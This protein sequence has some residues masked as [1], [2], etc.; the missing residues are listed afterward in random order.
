[1][2]FG[3]VKDVFLIFS[4]FVPIPSALSQESIRNQFPIPQP[5]QI[6]VSEIMADPAPA[7]QLP[8]EYVELF[9]RS[10]DSVNIFNWT[11]SAGAH[12]IR[13][14]EAVL[15]PGEYAVICDNQAYSRMASFSDRLI[16]VEMPHIT[17]TG[18]VITLRS[19]SGM[20]IHSVDFSDDWYQDADKD[21]GGWALEI[22]DPGNP[23]G[24]RSNW[25]AS[26]DIR[27][28]TPGTQ[29][30]VFASNPDLTAPLLLR[31]TMP[32]DTTVE[33]HFNESLNP[34]TAVSCSL[35]SVN[36][37]VYHPESVYPVEPG[38]SEILLKYH[39][40]FR[41]EITYRISIL[42]GLQDCAGN[43][44]GE[45]ISA[46]F[47]FAAAAESFDLVIN[48]ILFESG[49]SGE[50][51]EIYN[52]S[53]KVIDLSSLAFSLASSSTSIITRTTNFNNEQYLLFPG[54][55][56]VL[57]RNAEELIRNYKNIVP[58]TLLEIRSL[59]SLPDNEGLL[60]LADTA[61]NTIDECYYNR[62]RHQE[63]LSSTEGI[64]LERIN[65]DEASDDPENWHSASSA[66]EFGTPGLPNS[67][68]AA[69]D[70]GRYVS[71]APELLSPDGDGI[72][73]EVVIQL[74]L[75]EPGW[76]GTI[77]IY[78]LTGVRIRTL[79]SNSLVGTDEY[80][81][82]DGK[83][84]EGTTAGAGLYVVFGELFSSG[85]QTKK[86]KKVV[87]IVYK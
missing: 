3:N 85:G 7:I 53:E 52:R 29:N 35:Y 58:Q 64:S 25:R 19:P 83:D 70:N 41:P 59:F 17:N 9:N 55:Y 87:P 12:T 1:M 57:T 26:V 76:F 10:G 22:I 39:S 13:I 81:A 71:L 68:L 77:G 37:G 18:Q 8:D 20:V 51:V 79:I 80:I 5:Y 48:E 36:N 40:G 16:A 30:S 61:G 32:S 34:M 54:R 6:I 72:D 11:I 38:F 62:S 45:N 75:G 73:D 15:G 82:W 2:I 49:E 47:A 24:S 43:H 42:E 14:P 67:Q 33:L 56:L 21:E 60:V 27:G 69:N 65:P 4:F 74:H 31:A 84:T 46:E 66:S 44:V 28:G 78:T 23:C 86:F 50:F 63:L